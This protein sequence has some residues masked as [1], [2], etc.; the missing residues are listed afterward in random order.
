MMLFE[1]GLFTLNEPVSRYIP[2]FRKTM[3]LIE[4][5]T[6]NKGY[7]LVPPRREI[8]IRD[9]LSHTSGISYAFSGRP[10]IAEWYIK[11]GVSDCLSET[12]GTIADNIK[13]LA[14][15]PLLFHPGE[16]YE[17]GL[18]TDVLGYLVEI[19]SG[20]PLDSFFLERI[21]EPIGMKDTYFFLPEDKV[22]RLVAIYDYD[23]D[24][25]L[26]KLE[27]RVEGP[28]FD[29]PS[30]NTNIYDPT[31]PY[32]GPRSCFSGG[33]GLSSTAMDYMRLCQMILNGGFLDGVRLLGPNTVEFMMRNHAGAHGTNA[34]GQGIHMGFGGSTVNNPDP[35]GSILPV[36]TFA[37]GG[38]YATSF[39]IDFKNDM[40]YVFFTQRS[41]Y[42]SF[43][44]QE[45]AKLR[46]MVH[47]AIIEE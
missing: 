18:N 25:N 1:E 26:I 44:G 24:G 4:D 45:F 29:N 41:P 37:W 20:I 22:S 11:E 38:Y 17:Y 46:V 42:G 23:K 28:A 10:F 47:A 8:T 31:Y 16:G 36:G 7:R 39:D 6:Y 2:E 5:S 14:K 35:S 33:A 27:D 30:V 13:K 3:V 34:L 12:E 21:F 9:L 40:I 43:H 32:Q 15:C 19:V